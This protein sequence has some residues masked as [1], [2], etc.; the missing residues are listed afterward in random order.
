[1]IRLLGFIGE[2]VR[3]YEFVIFAS[4]I[5]SWLI[6]FNVINFNHPFVRSLAKAFSA[7]TEP[8]LK[9]IRRLMPDTGGIDFSPLILILA[10]WFIRFVVIPELQDLF[11][12]SM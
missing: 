2:L 9:P 10:C 1:M 5:M 7:V 8:L 3:L 11:R 6:A 12:V 4:V